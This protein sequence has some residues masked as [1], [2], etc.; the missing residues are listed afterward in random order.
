[1]ERQAKEISMSGRD[2]SDINKRSHAEMIAYVAPRQPSARQSHE[3]ASLGR[4][5]PIVARA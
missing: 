2:G 3:R 5:A 1:M 4:S